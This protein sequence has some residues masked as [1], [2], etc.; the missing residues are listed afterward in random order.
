MSLESKPKKGFDHIYSLVMIFLLIIANI[1]TIKDGHNWGGDFSQYILNALNIINGRPYSDGI[2]LENPFMYPPGFPFLLAPLVKFFGVNFKIFK[3]LNILFWYLSVWVL[4]PMFKKR[5]GREFA[6][7]SCVY[8]AGLS[9]FFEYKQNVLSDI[10]FMFF[11]TAG[12]F[13]LSKYFDS[14][15]EGAQEN[16]L[17]YLMGALLSMAVGFWTRS[18]GLM[19]FLAAG[20]YALF[21]KRK[22]GVSLLFAAALIF[23]MSLQSLYMGVHKG[24]FSVI[25]DSPVTFFTQAIVHSSMALRSLFWSLCPGQMFLTQHIFFGVDRLL[26]FA[27][28]VLYAYILFL[29]VRKT[30]NRTLSFLGCFFVFYLAVTIVWSGFPHPPARFARFLFPLIGPWLILSSQGFLSLSKRVGKSA[31]KTILFAFLFGGIILNL[32][33]IAAIF[34]FNDDVLLKKE[35]QA[36]FEWV[37]K[38]VGKDEHYIIWQARPVALMTGRVGATP[39]DSTPGKEEDI[40]SRIKRLDIR[41]LIL[42]PFVDGSLI[43]ALKNLP[44]YADLVWQNKDYLIYKV[45]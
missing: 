21:V 23:V 25:F 35:N 3:L 32:L 24:F 40:F 19:L 6:L 43:D 36:L 45:N 27:A 31:A 1:I 5:L 42:S 13:L 12:V 33:N 16:K 38:N 29:F 7:V 22:I 34:N 44:D 4:Y 15:K 39:I 26:V 9:F 11:T 28:P 20:F 10:P 18:A 8:V 14:F 37:K 41:Y 2:T 17:L 30:Q